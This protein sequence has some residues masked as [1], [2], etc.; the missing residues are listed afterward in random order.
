MLLER[1]ALHCTVLYCTVRIFPLTFSEA[2]KQAVGFTTSDKQIRATI[3]VDYDN[4]RY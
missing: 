1:T 3:E 2:T 4:Y